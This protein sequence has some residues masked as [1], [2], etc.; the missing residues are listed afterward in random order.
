MNP[1]YKGSPLNTSD[2]DVQR[3]LQN[4]TS[5]LALNL[6]NT[7]EPEVFPAALPL[8][9]IFLIKINPDKIEEVVCFSSTSYVTSSLSVRKL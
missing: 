8:C 7:I 6:S 5:P 4:M 1:M 9:S 3:D 2:P